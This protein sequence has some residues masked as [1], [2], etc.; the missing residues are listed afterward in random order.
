[1]KPVRHFPVAEQ[2]PSITATVSGSASNRISGMGHR[3]G[4]GGHSH[5]VTWEV[6]PTHPKGMPYEQRLNRNGNNAA[7]HPSGQAARSYPTRNRQRQRREVSCRVLC[8]I[9]PE[10]LRAVG[11][12]SVEVSAV[13][14]SSSETKARRIVFKRSGRSSFEEA[15]KAILQRIS[16]INSFC[17][18]VSFCITRPPWGNQFV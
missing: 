9:H 18:G 1:M 10:I 11:Y 7:T 12:D 6:P 17:L 15:S 16:L 8:W 13:T 14:A 5:R 2:K 3:A 4:M